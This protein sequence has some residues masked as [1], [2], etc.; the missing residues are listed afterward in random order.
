MVIGRDGLDQRIAGRGVVLFDGVCSLCDAT[1]RFVSA[2]DPQGAFVFAPLQSEAAKMLLA[3]MG[4]T[5]AP[6]PETVLLIEG[7]ELYTHSTAALRIARRLVW[8]WRALWLL[9]VVPRPLRDAVYRFV[10]RHRYRWFGRKD[11]CSRPSR[12]LAERFLD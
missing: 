8:P 11:T 9:I 3:P 2:R 7:G 10:A 4:T 5:P 12:V 1:V 6:E